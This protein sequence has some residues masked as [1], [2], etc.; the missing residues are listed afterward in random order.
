MTLASL[1]G[2]TQ[3]PKS[4]GLLV[5]A[6]EG[7]L[8]D[9]QLLHAGFLG[10]GQP[11]SARDSSDNPPPLPQEPQ[12]LCST[13]SR[14][15]PCGPCW[16]RCVTAFQVGLPFDCTKLFNKRRWQLLSGKLERF[17]ADKGTSSPFPLQVPRSSSLSKML[18]EEPP[19]NS[20]QEFLK[21][22]ASQ[23]KHSGRTD[24]RSGTK[25][26][27]HH[28]VGPSAGLTQLYPPH[29]V[30]CPEAI[31]S[32]SVPRKLTQKLPQQWEMYLQLPIE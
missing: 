2:H 28:S 19:L 24:H 15:P 10:Q 29:A 6:R 22:T 8:T 21:G 4:W 13:A 12:H 25:S 20:P 18:K 32:S 9:G 11:G 5:P 3:P 23:H 27:S 17:S 1:A 26:P 31:R 30:W 7:R 16:S 14:S